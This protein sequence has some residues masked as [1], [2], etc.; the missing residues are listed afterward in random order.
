MKNKTSKELK[1]L[2]NTP[3]GTTLEQSK[4]EDRAF[5]LFVSLHT[6]LK[7]KLVDLILPHNVNNFKTCLTPKYLE[8]EGN[9]LTT[10][11]FGVECSINL[12]KKLPS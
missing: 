9:Q 7:G 5:A 11:H 2:Q 1:D 4:A 6:Q 10:D 8:A 12:L 3:W